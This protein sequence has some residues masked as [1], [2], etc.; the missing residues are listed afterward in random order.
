[1]KCIILA[2][3]EGERLK[4]CREDLPKPLCRIL[5]IPLIERVVLTF[6][7]AGMNRFLIVTGY[8][9]DEVKDLLGDGSRYGVSIEYHHNPQWHKGN[10]TSLHVVKKAIGTDERFLVTMCD[11]LFQVEAVK[12]FVHYVTHNQGLFLLTDRR[13]D[14]VRNLA[15]ATKVDV[16]P[17]GTLK[18][19]GKKLKKCSEID[20]GLLCLDC[21]IY[22]AL[23]ESFKEGR[24]R[25]SEGIDYLVN[26]L[27]RT[28]QTV[29]IENFYWQDIDECSD[30]SCAE[31]KM[32]STL[33][34]P[35]DGV[36]STY[37]NRR[38]SIPI[39]KFISRFS[40]SPNQVSF[41]VSI[42][43]ILSGVL[44]F[45]RRPLPA[46]V[47]A[48]VNSILDG[49][50]GEIA[51]LKHVHS[52]LGGLL[53][54]ILDR[55]VDTVILA[56]L[57]YYAFLRTRSLWALVLGTAALAATP[58]SMTLKDRF[59]LY[60][61]SP[62]NSRRMDGIIKFLLPNRDGRLFLIMIGGIVPRLVLPV[63]LLLAVSSNVQIVSRVLL[64]RKKLEE[65]KTRRLTAERK[66]L[67]EMRS[68]V[69]Q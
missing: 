61:G 48:Q 50:D 53:D 54:S 66:R 65:T 15:E 68:S 37:I 13:R 6:S 44:F 67:K 3:G 60:F 14:H 2:A 55:Y 35:T 49:V 63:L 52:T 62:Y 12:K 38:I 23:E 30:I 47:L 20:C 22:E 9:G 36:V 26:Q 58:L 34:S 32:L 27:G 8:K 45:L 46:G 18:T 31:N 42:V 19:I 29:D 33:P 11:H 5:G 16:G 59:Y 51:R 17:D 28:I 41:F 10:G 7:E 24:Y 4:E 40:I 21:D 39:T 56:G 43:G 57:V 64:I 69:R 1:M 25:L